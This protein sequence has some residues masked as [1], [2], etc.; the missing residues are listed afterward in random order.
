MKIRVCWM[1]KPRLSTIRQRKLQRVIANT[2]L[3][4][5]LMKSCKRNLV[6]GFSNQMLDLFPQLLRVRVRKSSAVDKTWEKSEGA[7]REN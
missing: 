4:S 3:D 5:T 6:T 1:Y 7:K 2:C